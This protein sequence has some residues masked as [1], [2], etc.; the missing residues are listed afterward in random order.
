MSKSERARERRLIRERVSR[1][2]DG[3]PLEYVV[4]EVVRRIAGTGDGAV[5]FYYRE[6]FVVRTQVFSTRGGE[7]DSSPPIAVLGR[8]N[9]E[10]RHSP[11]HGKQGG[12]QTIGVLLGR[13]RSRR[14]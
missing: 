2:L 10:W 5:T 6:G 14:A 9:D 11:H 8:Q 13:R 1:V 7:P 12:V 4:D 3:L